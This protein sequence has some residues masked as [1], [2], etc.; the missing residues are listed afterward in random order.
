MTWHEHAA[1]R[2]V[3]IEAFFPTRGDNALVRA[4]RQ[5]CAS[6]PVRDE[7]LAETDTFPPGEDE[8][9]I[10]AGLTAQERMRRRAKLRRG[11]RVL[12][13]TGGMTDEGRRR[14]DTLVEQ[15][16]RRSA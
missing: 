4:A 12:Q 5:V 10:R 14:L 7:C 6:C 15:Y 13:P 1:C 9:G 3:P 11:T 2:G 8:H 16:G